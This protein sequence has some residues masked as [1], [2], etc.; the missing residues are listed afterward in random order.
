MIA[1]LYGAPQAGEDY[2][3]L[4]KGAVSEQILTSELVSEL[5]L[6]L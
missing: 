4:E 2:E 1:S 6:H 5:N 3:Y